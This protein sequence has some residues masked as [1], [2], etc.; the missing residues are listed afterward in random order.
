M[1]PTT[2]SRVSDRA[3]SNASNSRRRD[4]WWMGAVCCQVRLPNKT[5]MNKDICAPLK[6]TGAPSGH[7]I[8]GSSEYRKRGQI[9]DVVGVA[10]G[11]L[12]QSIG[13]VHHRTGPRSH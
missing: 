5:P 13:E 10:K 2:M 4:P 8:G 12:R 6:R 9:H 11:D 1:L 7:R 3:V